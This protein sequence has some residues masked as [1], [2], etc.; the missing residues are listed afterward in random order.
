M[1]SGG[2]NVPLIGQKGVKYGLQQPAR[3]GPG[4]A[5]APKQPIS[6]PAA[7]VFGAD[8]DSDEGVEAQISR[9]ADKK[10]AAAKVLP[11]PHARSMHPFFLPHW[12][13][14]PPHAHACMHA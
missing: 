2:G 1:S 13:P 7:N 14:T 12:Q 10:R 4:G 11:M 3:R 5:A 6:R 8:S 9:Q